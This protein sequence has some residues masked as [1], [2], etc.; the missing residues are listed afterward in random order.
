MRAVQELSG[1]SLRGRQLRVDAARRKEDMPARR[2]R[3]QFDSANTLFLGNLAWDV[4]EEL[5]KEMLDDVVGP[6]LYLQVGRL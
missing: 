2:E 1:V 6:G 3:V 4:T 5:L